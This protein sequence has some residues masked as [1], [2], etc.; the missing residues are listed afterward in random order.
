MGVV[1]ANTAAAAKANAV[2]IRVAIPMDGKRFS[3]FM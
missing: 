3:C 1:W 2:S